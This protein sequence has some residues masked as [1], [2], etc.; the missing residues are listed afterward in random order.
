ML[1]IGFDA[2]AFPLL[3]CYTRH[4]WFPPLERAMDRSF[5]PEGETGYHDITVRVEGLV[6]RSSLPRPTEASPVDGVG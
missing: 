1:L 6:L 2:N 5:A 4:L 3:S